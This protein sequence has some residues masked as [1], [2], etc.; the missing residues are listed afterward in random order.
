MLPD[1]NC[2]HA[3]ASA[4]VLKKQLHC[5]RACSCCC[6]Q[7]RMHTAC[8]LGGC[9]EGTLSCLPATGCCLL[10]GAA[11]HEQVPCWR[12]VDCKGPSLLNI[13]AQQVQRQGDWHCS[14][15]WQQQ[16]RHDASHMQHRPYRRTPVAV[17]TA[18]LFQRLEARHTYCILPEPSP[19]RREQ[20]CLLL[21]KHF[22]SLQDSD[23]WT[24]M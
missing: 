11:H 16:Q 2:C 19:Q 8:R 14:I 1:V 5:M 18:C 10:P 3:T 15:T 7:A 21:I 17:L 23:P 12:D 9:R 13:Q 20:G 24:S 6:I 4:K 22:A